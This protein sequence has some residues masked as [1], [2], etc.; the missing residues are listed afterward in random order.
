MLYSIKGKVIFIDKRFVVVETA[1]I[2]YEIL[3]S[4]PENYVLGEDVFLYLHHHLKEDNEYLAGF[5]DQNEQSAFNLLL[6]VNGIGPKSALTIL[7]NCTYNE[8]LFAISNQD[9][10]FIKNIPGIGERAANQILL[11]LKGYIAKSNKENT[12]QYSEAK[13]ALKA[14]KWKAKDIDRV[15]SQIYMPNATTQDIILEA[16][17]RLHYGE[18][19]GQK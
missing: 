14:L 7:S 11:D 3:V 10:D 13:Q 5:K 1:G 12:K 15:L 9:A 16:S 18:N 4:K 17:R 19:Y 8:L 2:G 6:N